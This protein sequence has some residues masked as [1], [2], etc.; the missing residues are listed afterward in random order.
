MKTIFNSDSYENYTDE[1]IIES[2]M[3]DGM[4]REEITDEDIWEERN[5]LSEIHFQDEEN[6]L[7]KELNN[8]I[9]VIASIGKWNGRVN[10]YRVISGNL[11]NILYQ[12]CGDYYHV[13]Y[14]GYNILAKDC[15]HD[16]TN[17]YT[18]RV[19]KD[20]IIEHG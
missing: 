3:E 9:L 10:G 1:D 15:H 19:I 8:D 7:N 5:F 17:Y 18:F 13:Y 14:D 12:A 2:L 4:D 11:Q 16:G 20:N 6:N